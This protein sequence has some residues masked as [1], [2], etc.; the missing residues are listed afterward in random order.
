MMHSY[1]ACALLS[2]L[3]FIP[4]STIAQDNEDNEHYDA[5]ATLETLT[6]TSRPPGSQSL[7]HTAQPITI[8]SGEALERRQA[9]T[10]GETLN[11]EPGVTGSHFGAGVSR[12]IIRGLDGPRVRVLQDGIGTLDVSTI[13][14]DHQATVEPFQAEQIEIMRGPAT[15]LY[16][17]GASGG[18]VNVVTGRIPEYVPDFEADL[19]GQYETVNNGRTLGLR[20]RGGID[21][22]AFH[23]DGL[24]RD[25]GD[26]EAADGR[27]D[28][29]FVESSNYN[30]GTSWVGSRGFFGVSF[31][32]YETTY[33]IPSDH[34][35]EHEEEDDEHGHEDVFIDM[36]QDRFDFAG[37]LEQPIAALRSINFRAGYNDYTHTEFEGP[38]EVG[39]VFENQAWEGR[40]EFNHQM[41]GPFLGTV[42]LQLLDRDYQ[43]IGE[44]AFV[45]P[46]E[47]QSAGLFVFED[48]DWRDWHFELGGRIEHQ[49]VESSD[50]GT[51]DISHD[52]Y[53]LSGGALWEF[54]PGYAVGL[55]ATRA[56]RAP[57][58]EELLANGPHLAT[59][60]FEIGDAGLDEETS[61]NLDLSLRKTDGRLTWRANVFI[62]YIENFIFLQDQD[63]DGDGVADEVDDEGNPGGELLLVNHTQADALFYGLEAE[64]MFGLFDDNRGS[65]DARLF[66]DWVRGRLDGGPDLPRISPA[67]L[68]I[69]FDYHRGPF[70]A[71]I[72]NVFVFEQSRSAPLET[73]TDGYVMLNAGIGYTLR[74]TLADTT[75]FLRGRNLLDEDARRHTSFIKDNAPL[76]GR[77]ALIG[78]NAKF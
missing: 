44:E 31:G 62:N 29:S 28:N 60:T 13:S 46:A 34:G 69:G 56:Q 38:G 22:F 3:W 78:V 39:T 32:R 24:E 77:S 72:E 18:L 61:N 50:P 43:A 75:L 58:T 66:G 35:H 30:F 52:I 65:L 71:D 20:A 17:S 42:G 67:R 23:F 11:S 48:T 5:H 12:P 33:G 49:N 36:E 15:L 21:Q 59:G 51:S 76:A 2:A 57:A 41:I 74:T 37:R 19:L 45:P 1:A 8:L 70:Q 10:L 64:V 53:S 26:Y 63:L 27:V 4:V 68:G 54:T 6:I 25:A 40:L 9:N 14:A 16:G 55:N 73:E 7:Q 47:Q